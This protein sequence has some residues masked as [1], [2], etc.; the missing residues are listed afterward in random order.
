MFCIIIFMGSLE[1]STVVFKK[2]I[3][4]LRH[5]LDSIFKALKEYICIV[6]NGI[7]VLLIINFHGLVRHT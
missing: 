3:N 1:L 5:F 7:N 2:W 6:C 4:Q